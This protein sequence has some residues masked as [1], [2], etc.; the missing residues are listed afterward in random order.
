MHKNLSRL[1]YVIGNRQYHFYCDSDAQTSEVKEALFQF[2]KYVGT[3]E[4]NFKRDQE[5]KAE[6]EKVVELEQPEVKEEIQQSE[7]PK[8]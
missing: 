6:S 1:E 5:Q 8:C 7:A 2:L 4:D 3:I